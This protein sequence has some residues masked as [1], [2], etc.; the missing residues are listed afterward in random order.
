MA[1]CAEKGDDLTNVVNY[2][3]G[4]KAD[5]SH[6]TDHIVN[7]SESRSVRPSHANILFLQQ[8]LCL[9]NVGFVE[10]APYRR[11]NNLDPMLMSSKRRVR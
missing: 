2:E 9:R 6:H 4:K 10:I 8:K 5:P 7:M 3:S 1:E 11:L